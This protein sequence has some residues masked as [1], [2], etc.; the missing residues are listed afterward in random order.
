MSQKR[1]LNY[2]KECHRL[3]EI[4]DN[5]RHELHYTRLALDDKDNEVQ[6]LKKAL[7]E[8][9]QCDATQHQKH[10]LPF[11]LGS[12]AGQRQL[13]RCDGGSAEEDVQT[14]SMPPTASQLQEMIDVIDHLQVALH[15]KEKALS[16]CQE[17]NRFFCQSIARLQQEC[18]TKDALVVE[19]Q[20]EIDKFRQVVK[21]LTQ[22]F[23]QHHKTECDDINCNIGMESTRVLPSEYKRIKRQGCSAEPLTNL[24]EAEDKLMKIPKCAK[25]REL[26]KSA[27]LDNDFMKN[28]DITQIREIVDCMYPVKYAAKSLIIKEGD[29]GSIVYVMEG[30]YSNNVILLHEAFAFYLYE[31]KS[32][33]NIL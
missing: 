14:E 23:L 6:S 30:E 12:T 24:V 9:H 16:E 20:N 11:S 21:P 26:I 31:P 18:H 28:L 15:D 29:V 17:R 27:I 13:E 1:Q 7:R 10:A 3:E 5:L 22:V 33:L 2:S 4:L 8:C 32:M 19:L 25:S